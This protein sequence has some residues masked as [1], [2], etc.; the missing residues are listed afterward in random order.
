M[1]NVEGMQDQ[2]QRCTDRCILQR[3]PE[4]PNPS[5]QTIITIVKC[6][7]DTGWMTIGAQSG[8]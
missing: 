4:V 2:P 1:V 7:R 3:F 5:D 6:L 8:R